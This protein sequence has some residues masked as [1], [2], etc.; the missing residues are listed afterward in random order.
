MFQNGSPTR[1]KTRL[2]RVFF[3]T[4][5]LGAGAVHC[6]TRRATRRVLVV[7]VERASWLG[8]APAQRLPAVWLNV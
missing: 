5:E 4:H 6:A 8:L 1:Y 2:G 7:E 3:R